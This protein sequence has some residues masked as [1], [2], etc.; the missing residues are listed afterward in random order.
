MI[1]TTRFFIVTAALAAVANAAAVI[2]GPYLQSAASDRITVCWRTDVECTS[3][4]AHATDAAGPFTTITDPVLRTDHAVTITGL[5]ADRL[6]LY[7]IRGT[8]V[9]GAPISLSGPGQSF[10]TAPSAGT[11]TNTRV[12]VVGDSG[13]Q[14]AAATAVHNSYLNRSAA[15]GVPTAAMFMLGDNAYDIGTDAQIGAAV[16]NR[17][18]SIL[19]STPVWS[20]FGNHDGYAVAYP[21]T[22]PTPYD[23]VFQFP[24]AGECGG[25]PSGTERYYSFN[26]GDIHF[27]SLDTNTPGN[28]ND[29]PGGTYG[30]VDWLRDDLKACTSDWIVVFMHQ[31]PY[32]KGPHDSDTEAWSVQSRV[33]V[34]PLLERYGV[35]LVMAA[36]NHIY[37][38]SRLIDGHYGTSTTW[39]EA[40]MVKWS[41]NG[42]DAGGIAPDGTFLPE[43][44][45]A[46]GVF[47]KPAALA[48]TGTVYLVNGAASS[49]LGWYGGNKAVV[50]PTPHPAHI[51]NLNLA[52]SLILDIQG[53]RLHG[54]YLDDTNLIRD[55][56][57]I[58]KGSTFELR[59]PSPVTQGEQRG[60]EFTV[61]RQG[62]LAFAQL[63]PLRIQAISG[64]TVEPTETIVEFVPGQIEASVT[65]FPTSESP[66]ARFSATLQPM[67]RPVAPDAAPR[68]VYR[69][70]GDERIAQFGPTSAELWYLSRFGVGPISN[71]AWLSDDDRDQ[72]PLLMEYALGGEPDRDDS[73]LLPRP[74]IEGANFV[75]RYI[76]PAGRDDLEYRVA[77]T[78]DFANWPAQG[79]VDFPDGPPTAAG[80]PR[81]AVFPRTTNR[82]FARLQVSLLP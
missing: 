69:I 67:L 32:S 70:M 34:I 24:T 51:A 41:G 80:E 10:R 77:F 35:D 27:I 31:A 49:N 63:V 76:R 12:W 74:T 54:R 4:V 28:Y 82:G 13:Y 59:P 6:H 47:E 36:H 48:R 17:Y 46:E 79:V 58:L 57:T 16:F 60:V 56:F 53:H 2:R 22:A 71:A 18:R 45:S 8:P 75:F 3:E 25:V 26:H 11:S 42:S 30:M 72:L 50:N 44:A 9:S 66:N 21:Y 65:F 5:A 38:R 33:H 78:E 7:Q 20:A 40:T 15:E 37:E 43:L 1:P 64:G 68:P 29:V 39:D 81:K 55:D 14:F 52:G 73:A 62:S 23:A 61:T 19:K